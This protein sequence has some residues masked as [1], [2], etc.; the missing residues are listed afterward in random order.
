MTDRSG[1][2]A[3]GVGAGLVRHLVRKGKENALTELLAALLEVPVIAHAFLAKVAAIEPGHHPVD[4]QTQVRDPET[5]G[6]PDLVLSNDH[7]TVWVEAKLDAGFTDKQPGGYVE[8]L[9]GLL[10]AQVHLV[11]LV[12]SGQWGNRSARIREMVNQPW[13]FS[14]RCVHRDVPITVATW[15]EV[16]DAFERIVIEDPVTKYLL[17]EFT[18]HISCDV[19]R[20]TIPLTPER[21]TVLN[22]PD[23]LSAFVALE[24]LLIDLSEQLEAKGYEVNG[25]SDLGQQGFLVNREGEEDKELW[26]GMVARAGVVWPEHGA[27][28]AWLCGDAYDDD[29][30]KR[31]KGAGFEVLAPPDTL[32]DWQE[33]KLAA[34]RVVRGSSSEQVHALIEQIE[35][36]MG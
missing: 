8:A 12:K 32:P 34:L 29:A 35:C 27:L 11:F 19:E 28:W 30:D 14:R 21:I 13:E 4:V 18:S 6:R 20:P 26:V 36:I 17:S 16:R 25:E 3:T 7:L 22:N 1:S 5:G 2:S 10:P 15:R 24:D 9:V 23:A 33:C 31:I